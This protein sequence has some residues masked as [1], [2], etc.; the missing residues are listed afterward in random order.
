MSSHGIN[1]KT[2]LQV[3]I[4]VG[5]SQ[6]SIF[7]SISFYW[8]DRMRSLRQGSFF[9]A[10]VGAKNCA[11][12]A[13]SICQR[14]G[15]ARRQHYNY[16]L[17]ISVFISCTKDK[18]IFRFHPR[19]GVVFFLICVFLTLVLEVDYVFALLKVHDASIF[20]FWKHLNVYFGTQ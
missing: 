3:R 20:I 1:I 17:I 12:C 4:I 9:E 16:K 15:V 18:N 19:F 11:F 14:Q 2:V 8:H 7:F 13:C 5:Y 10:L 6:N